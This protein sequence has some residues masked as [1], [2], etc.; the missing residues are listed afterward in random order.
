VQKRYK[1][2]RDG[3][4]KGLGSNKY[5]GYEKNLYEIVQNNLKRF[6]VKEKEHNVKLV[7]G[8]LQKTM[9]INQPVAFAHIDVDWYDP[10]KVSLERIIPQL[11]VGGSV[12]LDDYNDW[13]GC[14][15][16]TDE[17]FEEITNNFQMDESAGSMK[18]TRIKF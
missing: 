1:I 8:L 16:A 15:K 12:I 11:V 2:I 18:I 4:S 9:K 3:K 13:S 10:V 14:R 17:Y 7:K 6:G 5:Y